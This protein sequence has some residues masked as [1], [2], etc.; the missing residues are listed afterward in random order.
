MR[1]A[2]GRPSETQLAQCP[3]N[4]RVSGTQVPPCM[5][6]SPP[7]PGGAGHPENNKICGSAHG[8]Y[9]SSGQGLGRGPQ[10]QDN[11]LGGTLPGP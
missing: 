6:Y 11:T 9:Q 7:P 10:E 2:T 4:L 1:P 8:L 5:C 3:W